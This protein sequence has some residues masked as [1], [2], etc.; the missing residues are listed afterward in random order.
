MIFEISSFD[1]SLL[2]DEQIINFIVY[3]VSIL[4]REIIISRFYDIWYI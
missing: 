4:F 1:L 2:D 3:I